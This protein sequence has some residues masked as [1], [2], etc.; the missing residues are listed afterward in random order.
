MYGS[1]KPKPHRMEI[2]LESF[3]SLPA[4]ETRWPGAAVGTSDEAGCRIAAAR[5]WENHGYK[6]TDDTVDDEKE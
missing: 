4:I 3:L 6:F 5:Y 1:P 2:R